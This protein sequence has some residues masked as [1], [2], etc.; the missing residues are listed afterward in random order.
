MTSGALGGHDDTTIGLATWATALTRDAITAAA[1]RALVWD[2]LD[3]V[4]C[5]VTAVGAPS[6]IAVRAPAADGATRAG[7]SVVGLT[8]R[9][10]PEIGAFANASVVRYLDCGDSYLRTGGGRASDIIAAL[11]AL[12]ELR[13]ASGSELLVGLHAGY[14]TFAALADA[15]PLRDRGWDYLLFIGIAAAVGGAALLGLS[16]EETPKAIPRSWTTGRARRLGEDGQVEA[17]ELEA[18]AMGES[19]ADSHLKGIRTRRAGTPLPR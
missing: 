18:V 3:S 13:G 16:T 4:G 9:V 1:A 14:V 5:A 12:A 6:C 15:V 17:A 19:N 10:S 7:V 8:E 11:W 2:H